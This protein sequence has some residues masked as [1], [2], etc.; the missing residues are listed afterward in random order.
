MTTELARTLACIQS[1]PVKNRLLQRCAPWCSNQQ[2]PEAS[3]CAEQ[4]RLDRS[5][6]AKRSHT[7]SL[8]RQL[9]WLPV[10]QRITYKLAVLTFKVRTT[11][12]STYLHESPPE[13][14]TVRTLR[15]TMSRLHSCLS[16][17]CLLQARF[18]L[19]TSITLCCS[20]MHHRQ[21]GSAALC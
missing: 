13:H 2:H 19:R 4:C 1:D 7:K 11:S 16:R 5:S 3:T 20:T 8:L 9:H 17:L 14:A 10:Q 18:Q 21:R 12:T 15:S 6:G